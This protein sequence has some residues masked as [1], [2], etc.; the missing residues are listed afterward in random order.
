MKTLADV[1]RTRASEHP[2]LLAIW[3]E[4]R[5]TSYAE[6]DRRSNQAANA[7]IAAGVRPGDRVCFLDKGHDQALEAILG[8]AKAGAVFTPVNYRL[9][10]PEMAY[11]INDAAATLLLVGQECAEQIHPIESELGQLRSVVRWGEGPESWQ[12]YESWR[13]AQGDTDPRRDKAEEDTVWQLYTSGTTGRPKGAELTNANLLHGCAA[14]QKGFGDIRRGDVAFVCMPLYHIGGSEYALALLYS[15]ASMVITRDFVPVQALKLLAERRVKHALFVP[16][17]LSFLLQTP[18]CAGTDFS[19]LQ[20]I[21][22]GA[23]PIPQDLLSRALEIFGCSF[24]QGYG[25]TETTGAVTLLAAE[26]HVRGGERLR[27]CGQPMENIATRVVDAAG[28]ECPTGEVGEV[29]IRGPTVMKGYWNRPEATSESIRNGWFHSGDAGYLD[30]DGY[31]F[32]HDCVKDMIVSGGENIYP[33]EIESLLYSH[34]AV[35]DVAVIGVPDERW[36]ETVKAVV[37]LESGANASDVDIMSFCEGKIAGYK[38]PRSVDFTD[39]LPRNPTGKILKREL[40]EKYWEGHTRR[41]N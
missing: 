37:V 13:D 6:L 35:A 19:Q 30:E 29:I 3:H 38:R 7:L 17:M 25:L 16:A 4:G 21:A 27:S 5:E 18:S 22:Y 12:S 15:G 20:S 33:A 31:L 10:P 28:A 39:E 36:G 2:E 41:V 14:S 32:I 1:I 26:D 40:R 8:L 23:S 24:I 9:A 11:V 34:P